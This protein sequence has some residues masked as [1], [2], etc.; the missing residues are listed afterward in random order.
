MKQIPEKLAAAILSGALLAGGVAVV[1]TVHAGEQSSSKAKSISLIVDDRPLPTD[2]KFNSSVAPIVKKVA[3]SV[4]KIEIKIGPKESS[5]GNPIPDDPFF[6]Q[7][8]GGPHKMY[9][10]P[11]HGVGSGVIVTKDGYI[12]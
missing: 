5:I 4:V 10:P 8:F 11:Q 2:L 1:S 9:S 7:F 3:P 12:L 6:R